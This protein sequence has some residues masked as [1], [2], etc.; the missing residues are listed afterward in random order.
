MQTDE[1]VRQRVRSVTAENYNS[2]PRRPNPRIPELLTQELLAVVYLTL[3]GFQFPIKQAYDTKAD[4]K[5][6][7]VRELMHRIIK[8]QGPNQ[9]FEYRDWSPIEQET[10]QFLQRRFPNECRFTLQQSERYYDIF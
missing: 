4:R 9:R 3:L 10:I 2:Y 5:K 1:E 6:A 8:S 7:W